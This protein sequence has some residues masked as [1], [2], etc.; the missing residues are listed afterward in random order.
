MP[1]CRMDKATA[2]EFLR[3]RILTCFPAGSERQRWLAWLA[4]FSQAEETLQLLSGFLSSP[5]DEPPDLQ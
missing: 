2:I 4:E 1:W 5:A 3:E